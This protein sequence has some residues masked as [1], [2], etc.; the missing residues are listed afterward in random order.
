MNYGQG[1]DLN[2]IQIRFKS[3]SNGSEPDSGKEFL[4]FMYKM[5]SLILLLF[6]KYKEFGSNILQYIH[7]SLLCNIPLL[8]AFNILLNI[9]SQ[10]LSMDESI[11]IRRNELK[12][13]VKNFLY[14]RIIS[15]YMKR[16]DTIKI[17]ALDSNQPTKNDKQ[18]SLTKASKNNNQSKNLNVQKKAKNTLKNKGGNKK[19]KEVLA[20]IL[21]LLYKLV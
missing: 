4:E 9:S 10:M 12:D 2:Q 19:N 17:E 3:D 5:E 15:I 13:N 1:P 21:V 14:E 20:E 6:E 11:D 7:N 18:Q 16:V 8:E